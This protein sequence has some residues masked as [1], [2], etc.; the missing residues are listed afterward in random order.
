MSNND[1][2]YPIFQSTFLTFTPP[3]QQQQQQQHPNINNN[4]KKRQHEQDLTRRTCIKQESKP[5][6]TTD[7]PKYWKGLSDMYKTAK[8]II[9]KTN[10]IRDKLNHDSNAIFATALGINEKDYINYYIKGEC[11]VKNCKRNHPA[12]PKPKEAIII[13]A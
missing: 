7:I 9:P 13:N 3:Q 6:F 2:K 12:N 5:S 4:I 1:G 10:L 11:W 8:V